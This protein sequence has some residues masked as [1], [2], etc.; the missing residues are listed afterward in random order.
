MVTWQGV[1]GVVQLLRVLLAP[2][3]VRKAKY[4]PE[5]TSAPRRILVTVMSRRLRRVPPGVEPVL[6][7]LAGEKGRMKPG[8]NVSV[9]ESSGKGLLD[10]AIFSSG[11]IKPSLTGR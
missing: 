8:G 4:V 10:A 11:E 1:L 5:M 3:G 7:L 6:A 2:P 9:G